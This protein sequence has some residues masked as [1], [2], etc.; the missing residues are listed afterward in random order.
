MNLD[1]SKVW[2][3]SRPIFGPWGKTA[4]KLY[5]LGTKMSI[6]YPEVTDE[7]KNL[8]WVPQYMFTEAYLENSPG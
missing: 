1:A 4:I 5:H 6:L 7:W 2:N 3:I 8:L